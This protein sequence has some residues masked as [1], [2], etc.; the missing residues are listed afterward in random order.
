MLNRSKKIVWLLCF[1]LIL[2]SSFFLGCNSNKKILREDGLFIIE[3]HDECVHL[4]GLTDEG[5][6]KDTIVV[7]EYIGGKLVT[8]LGDHHYVLDEIKEKYGEENIL[9]NNVNLKKVYIPF[10]IGTG[11]LMGYGLK[12]KKII[13]MSLS[14]HVKVEDEV[15]IPA[16]T[17]FERNPW[18]K[19]TGIINYEIYTVNPA[20]V[21]YYYNYEIRK[22]DGIYWIDDYDGE[23]ISYI[24]ENPYRA[25]YT[26]CG[27]YKEPECINKWDFEK[28]IV[29]E[30]EI[31]EGNTYIFKELKLYAKWI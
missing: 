11:T 22:N 14:D 31:T 4:Y 30:K 13:I 25:G 28:D 27:W 9:F 6:K 3:E 26:F 1:M 29:P 2:F 21:T 17:Y 12:R 24:P 19:G 8:S 15:K 10:K 7:P 23:L 20:N 16:K 5:V 18:Y